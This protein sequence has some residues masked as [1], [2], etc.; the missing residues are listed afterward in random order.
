MATPNA[1]CTGAPAFLRT[2]AWNRIAGVQPPAYQHCDRM[3]GTEASPHRLLE[4]RA[5]KLSVFPDRGVA[6]LFGSIEVEIPDH[7]L[8]F[9][10][11]RP[12]CGR[13]RHA[14]NILEASEVSR[15]VALEKQVGQTVVV[16][17]ER[18]TRERPEWP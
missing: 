17:P 9:G 11:S 7:S 6:Q 18:Q 13:A 16:G 14:E 1:S 3:R 12:S 15:T 8:P 2:L 5:Q 4:K 10:S